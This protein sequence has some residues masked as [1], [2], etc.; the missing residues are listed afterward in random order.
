MEETKSQGFL[1][2]RTNQ[3][4]IA[5]VLAYVAKEL[6][7]PLLPGDVSAEIVGALIMGLSL[8]IPTAM[9]AAMWFRVKARK[10]IDRIW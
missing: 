1:Q 3:W 7:L 5:A 9:A 10:I 6:G 4:L 8:F 2:S